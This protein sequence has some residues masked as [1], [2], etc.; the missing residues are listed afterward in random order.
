MILYYSLLL[1]LVLQSNSQLVVFDSTRLSVLEGQEGRLQARL[2]VQP[3]SSVQIQFSINFGTVSSDFLYSTEIT[4][5]T[6]NWN[7]NQPFVVSLPDN[8]VVHGNRLYDVNMRVLSAD[9]VFN[10][11][12]I[13]PLK[14]EIRDDE[15]PLIL[16]TISNDVTFEND[17]NRNSTITARLSFQPTQDDIITVAVQPNPRE[18]IASPNQLFFSSLNWSSAVTVTVSSLDDEIADGNIKYPVQFSAMSNLF[19][20]SAYN[21]ITALVNITNVDDEFPG[22]VFD[23]SVVDIDEGESLSVKVTLNYEPS[24]DVRINAPTADGI[25]AAIVSGESMTFTKNGWNLPQQL[26]IKGNLDQVIDGDYFRTMMFSSTSLDT[27]WNQ[28]SF[29]LNVTVR[30]TMGYK[31]LRFIPFEIRS[32][33]SPWSVTRFSEIHLRGNTPNV[34]YQPINMTEALVHCQ[35]GVLSSSSLCNLTVDPS[36]VTDGNVFSSIELPMGNILQ[37]SFQNPKAFCG[38]T[39]STSSSDLLTDPVG[40]MIQI[41]ERQTSQWLT[42]LNETVSVSAGR[43]VM[44]TW[45]DF[46]PIIPITPS[47]SIVATAIPLG[48]QGPTAPPATLK[49]KT[50]TP[51]PAVA[52]P[53]PPVKTSSPNSV[54]NPEVTM[55]PVI[56]TSSDD[57]SSATLPL[58]IIISVV[59]VL[60]ALSILYYRSV[61][62]KE[63]KGKKMMHAG[64]EYPDRE[65]PTRE[66]N[67][68][69]GGQHEL[70]DGMSSIQDLHGPV[71]E[72]IFSHSSGPAGVEYPDEDYSSA[73]YA[74]LPNYTESRLGGV[75][76]G[77]GK[78]SLKE[79]P[80]FSDGLQGAYHQNEMGPGPIRSLGRGSIFT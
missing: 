7:Q 11:A 75:L 12:I 48:T 80:S 32:G 31:F 36:L 67:N 57:D 42:V 55:T 43:N 44:S 54:T 37:I 60:C 68:L 20:N 77:R 27:N 79:P 56:A 40:W 16:L 72:E 52:T 50:D 6:A 69:G 21:G 28:L 9:N 22:L 29:P 2:G 46:C 35:G 39:I 74:P 33:L 78:P 41:K 76:S 8:V 13:Q 18:G 10:G 70:R 63:Q 47:P 38:V 1:V 71:V 53:N 58:T 23:P 34:G 4:F 30:D 49:P 17:R 26:V 19:S 59:I 65:A 5:T 45:V 73:S 15:I 25:D 66:L 62:S 61:K 51:K 64:D 3:G 14:V 24:V